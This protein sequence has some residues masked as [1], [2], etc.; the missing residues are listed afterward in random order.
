MDK[1]VVT[2]GTISCQND[3]LRCHQWRQCRQFDD[4]LFS[5]RN[6][7]ALTVYNLAIFSQLW[8]HTQEFHGQHCAVYQDTFQIAEKFGL[9]LGGFKTRKLNG[10]WPIHRQKF[11][12]EWNTPLN[13]VDGALHICGKGVR[14]LQ[15]LRYF[16]KIYII[17]VPESL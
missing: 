17:C 13:R 16:V 14:L 12:P 3:N 15:Q 4:L 6:G 1:I 7:A 8:H 10:I 11:K 2:G 9:T 5:V